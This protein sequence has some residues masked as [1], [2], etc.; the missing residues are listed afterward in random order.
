MG[1][2]LFS[3]RYSG[4]SEASYTLVGPIRAV[5][6]ASP[7]TR[8]GFLEP[9]MAFSGVRWWID[10]APADVAITYNIHVWRCAVYRR[11]DVEVLATPVEEDTIVGHSGGWSY[12]QPC[13]GDLVMVTINTFSAPPAVGFQIL[14]KGVS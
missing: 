10:P 4:S 3:R 1:P 12:D 11:G 8:Q 7:T 14:K 2:I 13:N 6:M 9:S 5:A